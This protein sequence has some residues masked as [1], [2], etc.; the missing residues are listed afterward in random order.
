LPL[1]AKLYHPKG[2]KR[3]WFVPDKDHH[4]QKN[5]PSSSTPYPLQSLPSGG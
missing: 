4:G 5:A 2:D 3:M 1:W